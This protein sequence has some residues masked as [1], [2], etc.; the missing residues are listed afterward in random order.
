MERPSAA[1]PMPSTRL[2]TPP[3]RVQCALIFP[4][5]PARV[6]AATSPFHLAITQITSSAKI[7]NSGS[8]GV[9]AWRRTS[10]SIRYKAEGGGTAAFKQVILA[11]GDI[12]PDIPGYACSENQIVVINSRG[13]NAHPTSYMECVIYANFEE[14]RTSTN[15]LRS[16][17]FT[18]QNQ[19]VNA[20]GRNTCIYYSGDRVPARD[21]SGCLSYRAN[22]WMTYTMHIKTGPLGSAV[23][24][25]T[26][27]VQPGFI[28]TLY[29]LYVA[30]EGEDYQLAHRQ[31]NL[32]VPRGQY[33]L[34]GDPNLKSSYKDVQRLRPQRRPCAGKIRQALAAPLHDQQIPR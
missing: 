9:N 17:E 24:S 10:S 19:R 33:Y 23:S 16:G 34:G 11:Q 8:P 15:G 28:K 4:R 18:R 30:Y 22:Q 7:R 13:A 12:S 32:V 21:R 27:K 20:S 26:G 29:E 6:S 3:A 1:A 31:E 25:S 14:G 5:I 2:S